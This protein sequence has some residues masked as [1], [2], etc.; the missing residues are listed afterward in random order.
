MTL[1]DRTL[2]LVIMSLVL[3]LG[4][5]TLLAGYISLYQL[6]TQQ[7]RSASVGL[8]TAMICIGATLVLCRHR[9]D[10]V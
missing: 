10:L 9:E 3:L 7:W 6:V 1:I 5:A 4:S 2:W 8:A